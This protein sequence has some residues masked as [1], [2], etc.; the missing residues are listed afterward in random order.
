MPYRELNPSEA[1]SFLQRNHVNVSAMETPYL[2]VRDPAGQ[3]ALVFKKVTG[4]V[5][6]IDISGASGIPQDFY[7]SAEAPVVGKALQYIDPTNQLTGLL[8]DYVSSGS[9]KA[10]ADLGN[11]L[12]SLV[13]GLA[14][15]AENPFG[16]LGLIAVIV[17]GLVVLTSGVGLFKKS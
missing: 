8:R 14:T 3:T 16:S 13:R 5:M 6:V 12:S 17:I 11:L 1:A 9:Y 4:E 7:Q 10:V 2:V 15:A